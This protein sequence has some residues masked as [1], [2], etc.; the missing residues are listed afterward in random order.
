MFAARGLSLVITNGNPVSGLPSAFFKI[1]GGYLGPLPNPVIFAIILFVIFYIVLNHTKLGRY[2]YCIG[3]NQVAAKFSGI[4]V[5]KYLTIIFGI[6][7]LTAGIIG[8]VLA[9][10]LRIGSPII[11]S[12]YEL[13]AIAAVAIGGTSLMGGEGGIV[14]TIIGALVLTV[15][16]NGLTILGIS[17]FFQQIIMGVII[18][19]VVAIDM[20]KRKR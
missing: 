16:R 6:N 7:G 1:S 19:T 10:R 8:V 4:N 9:S 12:G 13:D 18:I 14:G 2:T 3:S 11:A 15:I 17:T 5:D 20:A